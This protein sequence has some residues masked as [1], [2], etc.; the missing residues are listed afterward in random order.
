ME[1]GYSYQ[2]ASAR[3][4]YRGVACIVGRVNKISSANSIFWFEV[5]TQH[6]NHPDHMTNLCG[7][8][9]PK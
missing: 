2:E 8:A 4:K 3:S 7:L 5:G 6:F 9:Q 1:F